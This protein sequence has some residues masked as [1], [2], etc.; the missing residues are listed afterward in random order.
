MKRLHFTVLMT[1]LLSS[2]CGHTQDLKVMT[3]NLRF[4]NPA[5]GENKWDLRKEFLTGQIAF[6]EP[7]FFGTQE[8][9]LHQL[10]Y[11]DSTLVNYNW[12][13]LGRDNSPTGGEYSALFYNSDKYKVVKQATFWLS[14]TPEKV[15][16]GWDAM[17]ERICTLGFIREY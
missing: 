5:D 2:F 4:D 17:F 11:I 12:I 7:D 1:L 14:E 3:Y 16:K 6:Y 8:G 10:K 9:K 13:G 15:S